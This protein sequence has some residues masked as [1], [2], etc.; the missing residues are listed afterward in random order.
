MTTL[1]AAIAAT[2]P[3]VQGP[4]CS[5]HLGVAQLHP[6]DR[7]RFLALMADTSRESAWLAR[8]LTAASGRDVRPIGMARHRR[9]ECKCPR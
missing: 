9:G 1:D 5:V 6:D 4:K 7:E 8:V 2:P 3:M